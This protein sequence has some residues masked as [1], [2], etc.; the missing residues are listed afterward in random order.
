MIE[1]QTVTTPLSA[2]EFVGESSLEPT[3]VEDWTRSERYRHLTKHAHGLDNL[4]DK[5]SKVTPT[6]MEVFHFT[7]TSNDWNASVFLTEKAEYIVLALYLNEQLDAVQYL[8]AALII[9]GFQQMG[10]SYV[11]SP[12]DIPCKFCRVIDLQSPS[13]AHDKARVIEIVKHCYQKSDAPVY[14]LIAML[15]NNSCENAYVQMVKMDKK[16]FNTI[17][18]EGN[19]SDTQQMYNHYCWFSRLSHS[20]V[21]IDSEN[22]TLYILSFNLIN[23]FLQTYNN[24]Y[25]PVPVLGDTSADDLADYRWQH[26]HRIRLYN[27][28]VSNNVEQLIYRDVS[29]LF[30]ALQ[31][32][33]YIL[34]ISRID[35]PIC[36]LCLHI[37]RMHTDLR[38]AQ[39]VTETF[40]QLI[41]KSFDLA[42]AFLDTQSTQYA[43][44][45]KEY[46]ENYCDSEPA[47]KFNERNYLM[48]RNHLYQDFI[49]YVE[50]NL[51]FY[52]DHI[53]TESF[54]SIYAIH[55][56]FSELN[57]FSFLIDYLTKHYPEG[58]P[59]VIDLI[60]AGEQ[61]YLKK[62]EDRQSVIDGAALML[63]F[64]D[65]YQ[66]QTGEST[67]EQPSNMATKLERLT[68][69]TVDGAS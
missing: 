66:A 46:V 36:K 31:D 6:E 15:E 18:H 63:N 42:L 20:T 1:A 32:G 35:E 68:L 56:R 7:I 34:Q 5:L 62:A 12:E 48:R 4:N 25:E 13:Y 51:D 50:K 8:N 53:L 23:Q 22:C 43:E 57:R 44:R 40:A 38:C 21:A 37:D 14:G 19:T 59:I 60:K 49:P 26:K 16:T 29:K 52:F 9:L 30:S 10:Q 24:P 17:P 58:I 3:G 28:A 61:A 27:N 65:F 11:K 2:T 69:E 33:R 47:K 41:Q 67:A 55:Q 54:L 39:E 64:I 45:M